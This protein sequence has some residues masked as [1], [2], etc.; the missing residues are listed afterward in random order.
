MASQLGSENSMANSEHVDII[1]KFIRDFTNQ[2]IL[3]PELAQLQEILGCVK[4]EITGARR[5][6]RSLSNAE[7]RLTLFR[8]VRIYS[9]DIDIRTAT[10]FLIKED[11]EDGEW[12][13]EN[14][15]NDMVLQALMNLPENN[16]FSNLFKLL[17]NTVRS[18]VSAVRSKI[19]QRLGYAMNCVMEVEEAALCIARQEIEKTAAEMVV[20]VGKVVALE[21]LENA[22]ERMV[23][24]YQGCVNLMLW[25]LWIWDLARQVELILRWVRWKKWRMSLCIRHYKKEAGIW[26]RKLSKYF[27]KS[28]SWK[29]WKYQK[30]RVT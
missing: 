20:V 23:M 9:D 22:Y 21:D 13:M 28:A 24:S 10:W 11:G 7:I 18:I 2:G 1:V 29:E 16:M 19:Q 26:G 4:W 30:I 17:E 12:R 25:L 27:C 8:N 15:D 6:R 3:R 14:M 5:P